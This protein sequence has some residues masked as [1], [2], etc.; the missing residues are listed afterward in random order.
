MVAAGRAD[1]MFATREE[2]EMLLTSGESG[3]G[4]LQL[5]AFPNVGGGDTRH[6]LCSRRVGDALMRRLDAAIAT[7]I[8]LALR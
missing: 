8:R 6:I 5:L 1:A 7:E 2:A 3:H 4:A